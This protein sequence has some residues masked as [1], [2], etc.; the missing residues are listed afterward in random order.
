MFCHHPGLPYTEPH[1]GLFYTIELALISEIDPASV[2]TTT[3]REP[4]D[5][6][7][8]TRATCVKNFFVQ[9][10]FTLFIPTHYNRPYLRHLYICIIN[11]FVCCFCITIDV[12]V[13]SAHPIM[14]HYF[15][16]CFEVDG[17]TI[18]RFST[19]LPNDECGSPL[20]YY[21]WG[22]LMRN[23]LTA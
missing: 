20:S 7:S 6:P 1:P 9:K 5:T 23:I 11:Y 15:R 2:S 8:T 12:Q 14:R 17:V 13:H 22:V 3:S 4:A 18:T 21:C 16:C 10:N 19:Q